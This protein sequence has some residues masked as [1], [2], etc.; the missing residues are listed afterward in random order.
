[1]A[2]FEDYFVETM[3]EA[4]I[5][6]TKTEAYRSRRT[7][8]NTRIAEFRSALSDEQKKEFNVILNMINEADADFAVK[9]YLTGAE[10]GMALKKEVADMAK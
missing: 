2:I 1:M 7:A 10:N 9:A 3:E 5:S 8:V 4:M 6:Y